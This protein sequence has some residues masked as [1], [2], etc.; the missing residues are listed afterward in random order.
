MHPIPM[1]PFAL[2]ALFALLSAA[3]TPGQELPPTAEA[4]ARAAAAAAAAPRPIRVGLRARR[5][6]ADRLDPLRYIGGFHT[7][8]MLYETL[9]TRG[10]D[11][12]LAPGLA[13]RWQF[14]DD[15][16]AVRFELRPGARFHDGTAVTADAVALHFRRW[17]G[18]PEHDWLLA[19]RHVTGVTVESPTAFTVA[20]DAPYALLDDL[21]AINPCAI[22][23]PGA[24][25]WEGEFARP[26]GSGPFRFAEALDG[27]A[28]W[29]VERVLDGA[30]FEIAFFRRGR[31]SAP[32]DALERGDLDLFVGGWDEDLPAER[33]RAMAADP[34]F[35]VDRAAG[36]SV[37]WLSF[38]LDQGPT[39]DTALRRRVA[40]AID[41]AALLAAVEDGHGAPCTAWAA[42]TVAF[43]PRGRS[44]PTPT[45]PLPGPVAL[46]IAAGRAESRAARTAAAVAAQLRARGFDVE[47]RH[48][49]RADANAED[50]A[51]RAVARRELVALAERC[52]LRVEITH[53]MPYDPH[54]SL[55]A[56]FGPPSRDG[57]PEVRAGCTPALRELVTAV[58]GIPDEV[59]R[60]PLY[61]QIQ[62]LMDREAL[63]VPLFAPDRV[64]VRS[65]EVDGVVLGPDLYRVDL[66]GLHR[67]DAGEAGQ[68]EVAR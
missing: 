5:G 14:A 65:R 45:D 9:V 13:Q 31:D 47:L 22:A 2:S 15:G 8:T 67:C 28:R 34:R 58:A 17:L 68:A 16:R 6:G 40:A 53:G 43:W 46:T 4:A 10:D 48:A 29:R 18:L 42:P 49:P 41:R 66:T 26:M 39:R 30:P 21:C 61:A 36:S 38:R 55:V 56:R 59:E 20:L 19:N 24:R 64:L 60:V 27:G 1:L 62:E 52:D 50:A 35:C 57:E 23:G 51:A 37:V 63:V 12:R 25:D 44:V 54:R 11:G 32:L 7:K 3:Q 33:L